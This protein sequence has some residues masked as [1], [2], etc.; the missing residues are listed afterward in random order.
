MKTIPAPA[1]L[2][3]SSST[4]SMPS[5]VTRLVLRRSAEIAS[6][7]FSHPGGGDDLPH[8]PEAAILAKEKI[9]FRLTIVAWPASLRR[10]GEYCVRF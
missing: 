6:I 8:Y 10:H 1:G 5:G 9:D 2:P 4:I 7:V 3:A